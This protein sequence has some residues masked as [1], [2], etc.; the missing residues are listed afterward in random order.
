MEEKVQNRVKETVENI[1]SKRNLLRNKYYAGKNLNLDSV[2]KEP[3]ATKEYWEPKTFVMHKSLL[4][5]QFPNNYFGD[6]IIPWI[7]IEQGKPDEAYLKDHLNQIVFVNQEP[8][9]Q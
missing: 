7:I 9:L 8:Y 5:S 6:N 1:K 2:D 3:K 4:R